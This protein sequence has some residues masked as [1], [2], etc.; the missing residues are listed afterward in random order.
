MADSFPDLIMNAALA[1]GCQRVLACVDTP[2][3]ALDFHTVL[4][5]T[6]PLTD[7]RQTVLNAVDALLNDVLVLRKTWAAARSSD[8]Y[9]IL[10]APLGSAD[11]AAWKT[12]AAEI[13]RDDRLARKH[14]WLPDNKAGNLAPFIETTFLARPWG[15]ADGRVDALKLLTE[16]VAMPRGWQELLSDGELQGTELVRKLIDLEMEQTP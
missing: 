13:E 9:L 6:L 16:Q 5:A 3:I 4:A 15:A 10:A 12:L 14:V 2:L 8:L 7:D 11:Q 1:A